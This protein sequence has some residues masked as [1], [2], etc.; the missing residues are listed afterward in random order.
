MGSTR[1][2]REQTQARTA[3]IAAARRFVDAFAATLAAGVPFDPGKP[4]QVRE[5]TAQD[6]G[7]LRE[8]HAA[9]GEV[10][11]RRRAWDRIRCRGTDTH[12]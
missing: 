10:L 7:A 6:V 1:P 4:G 9:L 3:Y 8:L 11:D 12:R 2:E 5:W